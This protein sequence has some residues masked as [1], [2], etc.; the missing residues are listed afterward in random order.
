MIQNEGEHHWEK[1][2]CMGP[3]HQASAK[4][5]RAIKYRRFGVG[6]KDWTEAGGS[7]TKKKQ[8]DG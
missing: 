1:K 5:P 2:K 4:S 7:C 6:H 3:I 8:K